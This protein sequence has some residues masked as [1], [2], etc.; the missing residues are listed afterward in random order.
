MQ[1]NGFCP[2]LDHLTC[3]KVTNGTNS[4]KSCSVSR[5]GE[6]KESIDWYSSIVGCSRLLVLWVRGKKFFVSKRN[7][8]G[9]E[10]G[11]QS[12]STR[13]TGTN[14]ACER[15]SQRAAT[16]GERNGV[17]ARATANEM[18]G[19][20]LVIDFGG[21][22]RVGSEGRQTDGVPISCHCHV[23]STRAESLDRSHKVPKEKATRFAIWPEKNL[24]SADLRS[25][26]GII[27]AFI[28]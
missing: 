19:P 27:Y 11:E 23:D 7:G 6:P 8:T 9:G 12:T 24:M 26:K 15:S 21:A 17:L 1:K 10:G 25:E 16:F 18:S 13:S 3:A 5:V 4:F 22:R 28:I 14:P 2:H 20:E